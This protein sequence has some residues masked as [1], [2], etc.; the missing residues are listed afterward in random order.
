MYEMTILCRKNITLSCNTT[1]H[2]SKN[3]GTPYLYDTITGNWNG[4]NTWREY[5]FIGI[6]VTHCHCYIVGR[7]LLNLIDVCWCIYISYSEFNFTLNFQQN[8]KIIFEKRFSKTWTS[9]SC[10]SK[11]FWSISRR[12]SHNAPCFAIGQFLNKIVDRF[13]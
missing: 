2:S 12:T 3:K 10:A 4:W 5:T 11:C 8:V 7:G 6:L 9:C 13:V 1:S